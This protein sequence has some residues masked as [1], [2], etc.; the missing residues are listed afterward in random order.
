MTYP[1][2]D[3]SNGMLARPHFPLLCFSGAD[4]DAGRGTVGECPGEREREGKHPDEIWVEAGMVCEEG[5]VLLSYNLKV[6]EGLTRDVP[7]GLGRVV[8]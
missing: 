4:V 8:R 5:A 2:E 3:V 7:G 6:E 1:A